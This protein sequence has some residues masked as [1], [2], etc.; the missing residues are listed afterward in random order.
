[1]KERGGK[2]SEAEKRR[3]KNVWER[4]EEG[5][6]E[7]RGKR[8]KKSVKRGGDARAEKGG[9]EKAEWKRG[10]VHGETHRRPQTAT[11]RHTGTERKDTG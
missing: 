8:A 4:R 10:R 9:E 1:M 2:E 3:G 11:I 7:N 5:Y 6:K